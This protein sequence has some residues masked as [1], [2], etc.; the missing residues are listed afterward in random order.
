MRR[1][2]SDPALER[3][4]TP[5]RRLG[6]GS[7]PLL[8]LLATLWTLPAWAEPSVS[9]LPLPFAVA[10]FR[11]PA[12]RVG[13]T[14]ASTD[15]YRDDRGLAGQPLVVLWGP[16]GG[17]S[18]AL[19]GGELRVVAAR[20]GASDMSRLE[21]GRSAVPSVRAQAL[22]P[23]SATLEEPTRDYPHEAL[24]SAVHPAALAITERRPA[25]IGSEP[26][27]V[28][29]EVHRIPA[30][31][32][33]VF[34][35]REPRL[36]DLDGDGVPEVLAVR[37]TSDRGSS[38]AIVGRRDGGWRILAETPPDGEPFRW[39]NPA[40]IAPAV[41]GPTPAR[42][43]AARVV[44]LV[45]RPHLDGVL[46]LW[47]ATA[48]VLTLLAE[49]PGYS[50]HAYGQTAQDLAAVLV[51]SDGRPRLALPTLDRRSLAILT[52]DAALTETARI[53]LPSRAAT[54]VA[55]LGTGASVRILVGLEDGRVADIRP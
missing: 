11:G 15:T 34:E 16:G 45:R 18:V 3:A 55:A 12:S 7:P 20:R 30:G 23:F 39:L 43:P 46:Q 31:P 35:D 17:A 29:T 38:L 8:I 4:Q 28:P 37:S 51:G 41:A 1:G 42:A 53:P 22:G 24:G 36:V 13:Q 48:G 6:R 52:F 32:N 10:E 49:K 9:I 2:E 44:A 5:A 33:A 26:R 47:T 21:R 40:G 50:N 27:A 14:A 25:P 54:G 19:L